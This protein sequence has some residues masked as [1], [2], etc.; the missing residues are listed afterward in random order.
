ML[1][2]RLRHF[3]VERVGSA[4]LQTC[5][6]DESCQSIFQ[7]KINNLRLAELVPIC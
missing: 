3:K 5:A 4:E 1:R 7:H 2:P 6:R